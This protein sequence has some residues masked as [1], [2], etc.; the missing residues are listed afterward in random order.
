M[1]KTAGGASLAMAARK[2]KAWGT[3][4]GLDLGSWVWL[5]ASDDEEGGDMGRRAVGHRAA[6]GEY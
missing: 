5:D 3:K 1:A 4:G 2:V 6:A